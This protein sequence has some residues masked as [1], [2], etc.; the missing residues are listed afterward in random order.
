MVLICAI[1]HMLDS[2]LAR[3][4]LSS[5]RPHSIFDDRRKKETKIS[6]YIRYLFKYSRYSEE[7]FILALILLD[8]ALANEASLSLDKLNTHRLFATALMLSYKYLEDSRFNTQ[9]FSKVSHIPITEVISLEKQLL[10]LLN[11]ELFVDEGSFQRYLDKLN[12]FY[13]SNMQD[14]SNQLSCKS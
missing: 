10:K 7:T 6:A 12:V 5:S 9:H 14:S 1:G 13:Q 8:K 3:T 11:F 4:Q 2:F